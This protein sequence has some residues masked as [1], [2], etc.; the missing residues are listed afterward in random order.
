[1]AQKLR[2]LSSA[3]VMRCDLGVR[4][5]SMLRDACHCEPG[6]CQARRVVTRSTWK[7]AYTPE[8]WPA[9]V[10]VTSCKVATGWE[11]SVHVKDRCDIT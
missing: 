10:P 8:L 11:R 4:V 7:V 2:T 1:M 9:R 5:R 3:R 6:S